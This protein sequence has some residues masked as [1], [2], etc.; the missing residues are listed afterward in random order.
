MRS[1]KTWNTGPDD[2]EVDAASRAKVSPKER[3]R[4]KAKV[5]VIR[6]RDSPKVK[7]EVRSKGKERPVSQRARKIP[8]PIA[9]VFLRQDWTFCQRL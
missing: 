6:A 9:S 3:A 2:M 5:R 8:D 7:A 1:K 4:A